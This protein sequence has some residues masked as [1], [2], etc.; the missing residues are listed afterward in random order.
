M[1]RLIV[2][3]MLIAAPGGSFAQAPAAADRFDAEIR[4]FDDADRATP[5]PKDAVVFTG[6][7][8]IRLW[9]TIREDFPEAHALNRGFGGSEIEDAI[10]NVDRLVIRYRPSKVVFYSGDNDLN[11]GKT[12][13][14]VAADMKRFVAAVHAAL[15]RTRIAIISIKPS[16]ARWKLVDRMREANRL[17]QQ[18]AAGDPR[19]TYVDVFPL[20]LGPDGKPRPDLFVA[21]GLHMTA[22]GYAIWKK[23]LAPFLS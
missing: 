21:D 3:L 11:S 10:R 17:V 18:I 5:P 13:A 15:P 8:S 14:Q 1:F 2:G 23:A 12:P 19:L 22:A 20:M 7:S 4:R 9:T 16:L 6:S